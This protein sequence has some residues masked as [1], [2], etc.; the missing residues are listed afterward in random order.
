M[1]VIDYPRRVTIVDYENAISR[2]VGQLVSMPGVTTV[3]QIGG[4][5]NPGISDIDLVVVFED[6]QRVS[7]DPCRGLNKSDSYLFA[8]GLFGI[9]RGNFAEASRHSFFI[10]IDC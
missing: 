10:T 7:S 8:H 9:N 6:G 1:R 2:M 4:V 3:Y 5:S